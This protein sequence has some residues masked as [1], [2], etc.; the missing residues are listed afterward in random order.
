M[1]F[2]VEPVVVKEAEKKEEPVAVAA[3]PE[4]VAEPAPTTTAE[5]EPVV[6]TGVVGTARPSSEDAVGR[7]ILCVGADPGN[8]KIFIHFTVFQMV[9]F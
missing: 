6:P 3:A 2:Q 8:F 1:D 5:P 7:G 4:P 9:P